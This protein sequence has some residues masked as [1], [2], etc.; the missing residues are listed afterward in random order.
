MLIRR[1]GASKFIGATLKSAVAV[2]VDDQTLL[3]L[4]DA[5]RVVNRSPESACISHNRFCFNLIR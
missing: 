2:V 5:I 3:K 4:Q 1:D